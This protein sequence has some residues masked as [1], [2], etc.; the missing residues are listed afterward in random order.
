MDYRYLKAFLL[1]AQHSSFSR[2]ANEM[3][4]AQSAVSRQIKLLEESLNEELIIRSSKRVLLT[5]KGK[6]LFLAAQQFDKVSSNIFDRE[7][8]R[9][10]KI[11]LLHGL[12]RNWLAPKISKFYKKNDR[13]IEISIGSK[14]ELLQG[15]EDGKF[16]IIFSTQNIQ[17]D[18]I[19]SLKLFDERM[20]LI[21]KEDV[22]K[23]RLQDYRWVVYSEED[24]LFKV[25]KKRSKSIIHVQ[26]IHTIVDLVKNHVGIAIVPDHVLKKTDTLNVQEISGLQK[27]EIFMTTLNYKS[28]PTFVKDI[29]ELVIR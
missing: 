15:I 23:K 21:S 20:V 25:T 26:D 5:N 27:S 11:G 6:E 1:T 7:D 22:N 24:F 9:P 18:L 10:V 13:S 19:S 3:N 16:D 28:I 8:N 4:I 29:Q 2:A 12:L 17:S 14:K